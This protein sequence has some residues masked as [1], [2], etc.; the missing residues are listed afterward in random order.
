MLYEKDGKTLETIQRFI[1]QISIVL[2]DKNATTYYFFSSIKFE[3]IWLVWF[4]LSKT[5]LMQV[6]R[7]LRAS[8]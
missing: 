4:L 6:M 5:K 3:I 1:F 7:Q 2:S 8:A